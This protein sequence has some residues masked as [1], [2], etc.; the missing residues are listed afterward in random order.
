MSKQHG[1][2]TTC[3]R[4]YT[5]YEDTSQ[6]SRNFVFHDSN[7]GGK[8]YFGNMWLSNSQATAKQQTNVD[9]TTDIPRYFVPA[10]Q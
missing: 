10:R 4:L 7:F 8:G 6:D 9:P 1:Q 2:M 5:I 3:G